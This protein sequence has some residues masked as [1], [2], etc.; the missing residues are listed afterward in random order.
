[1]TYRITKEEA[2]RVL[3][4]NLTEEVERQGL[5]IVQDHGE[6]TDLTRWETPSFDLQGRGIVYEGE[7]MERAQAVFYTNDDDEKL[8]IEFGGDWGS[9][10]WDQRLDHFLIW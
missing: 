7:E 2:I 6:T 1:M 10:D 5:N 4:A 3:G 9:V 8:V